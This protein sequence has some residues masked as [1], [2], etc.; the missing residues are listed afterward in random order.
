[1]DRWSTLRSRLLAIASERDNAFLIAL[2]APIIVVYLTVGDGPLVNPLVFAIWL[3]E[4]VFYAVLRRREPSFTRGPNAVLQLGYGCLSLALIL[5]GLFLVGN[6]TG[7]AVV[8]GLLL[9]VIGLAT[10]FW[11]GRRVARASG[12]TPGKLVVREASIVAKIIPGMALAL[13]VF[14]VA[15]C[16]GIG[17]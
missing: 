4:G 15:Q 14:W 12:D 11:V 6:A 9:V 10:I 7:P 13:L 16:S 5:A 3:I 1:M 2:V 17:S 8:P